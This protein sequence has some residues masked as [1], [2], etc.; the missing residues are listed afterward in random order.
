MTFKFGYSLIVLFFILYEMFFLEVCLTGKRI[1]FDAK[2]WKA[3]KVRICPNIPL[4]LQ[5]GWEK[6]LDI[7]LY[8]V[9]RGCF[10]AIERMGRS[11]GG[12]GG[13]IVNVASVAG[14]TVIL[15][16][17]QELLSV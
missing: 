4:I 16:N 1:A 6:N 9:S 15:K 3:S 13:R 7:N 12:R 5:H 14:F 10:M 17:P 2:K 8:G 11:N